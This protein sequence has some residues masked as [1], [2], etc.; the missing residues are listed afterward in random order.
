MTVTISVRVDDET[1][2]DMEEI[3]EALGLSMNTAFALY[4]KTV[5]RERRI[6]LDLALD[7]FYSEANTRHL[8]QAAARVAQGLGTAHELI[9]V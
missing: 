7:P 6:P 4:A 3:C 2:K 5:V 1:K 8:E 9:E